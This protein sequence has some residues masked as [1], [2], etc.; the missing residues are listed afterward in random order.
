MFLELDI[1]RENNID[2][3]LLTRSVIICAVLVGVMFWVM[4]LFYYS[5]F[6][7]KKRQIIIPLL[8][9]K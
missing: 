3:A 2:L 1:V 9:K 4:V 6:I 8:T 7:K 5:I